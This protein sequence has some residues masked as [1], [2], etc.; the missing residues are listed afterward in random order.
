MCCAV[1]CCLPLH[2][3]TDTPSTHPHANARTLSQ[4]GR[5]ITIDRIDAEREGPNILR[6]HAI[7]SDRSPGLVGTPAPAPAAPAPDG[8]SGQGDS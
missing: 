3:P 4:G 6:V 8:G 7:S 5:L 2:P 1:L